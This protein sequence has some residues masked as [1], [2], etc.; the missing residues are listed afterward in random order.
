MDFFTCITRA[1][2]AVLFST[3]LALTGCATLRVTQPPETADEQFL[4]SRADS[5]AI[6]KI[7]VA[8]LRDR[9][10]YVSVHFLRPA[11]QM[12]PGQGFLEADLRS[13]LLKSGVRLTNTRAKAQIVMEVR[14]GALGINQANS[15]IGIPAIAFGNYNASSNFS[16]PVVLP[17]ISILQNTTQKGYVSV[18]YVA[19]WK[20]TGEIVASSGPFIGKTYRHDWWFLGFG[21]ETS[22]NIPPALQQ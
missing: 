13:H 21:P 5:L 19:Y 8:N 16:L 17:Q 4:L 10:V 18:A 22:G 3:L 12:L 15:F 7:S 20:K 11:G 6:S 14:C 1:G 2:S 9:L